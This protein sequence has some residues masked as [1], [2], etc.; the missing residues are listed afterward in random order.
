MWP[1]SGHVSGPG[2]GESVSTGTYFD[3]G[4]GT[5]LD[6]WE[7]V[8]VA[9][10]EGPGRLQNPAGRT[11]GPLGEGRGARS[12][13][14]G[15]AASGHI[16]CLPRLT[17]QVHLVLGRRKRALMRGSCGRAA[18]SHLFC[19]RHQRPE[20]R[21]S[22]PEGHGHPSWRLHCQEARSWW[23]VPA[24]WVQRPPLPPPPHDFLA[25]ALETSPPPTLTPTPGLAHPCLRRLIT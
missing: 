25:T 18:G 9:G 2:G 3:S 4:A 6:E 23:P 15:F 5:G 14:Q 13:E 24:C 8:G 21:V 22:S 12:Q 20:K 1:G 11:G 19:F 16:W 10:R 17:A 7:K